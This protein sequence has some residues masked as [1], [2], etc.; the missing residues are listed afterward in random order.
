MI[1]SNGIYE[2]PAEE[3]LAGGPVR[4]VFHGIANGLPYVATA[5]SFSE[6]TADGDLYIA[7]SVGVVK[8]N[9]EKPFENIG[10]LKVALP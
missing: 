5:N 8:V 10:E 9:I 4:P 6:L 7:S 3:L 1:S 2:I